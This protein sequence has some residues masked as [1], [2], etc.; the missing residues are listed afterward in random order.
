VEQAKPE[1]SP[2]RLRISD[3]MERLKIKS[4]AVNYN[5]TDLHALVAEVIDP[6][7]I[8]HILSHMIM[9]YSMTKHWNSYGTRQH[10]SMVG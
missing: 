2:E 8:A 3:D 5:T 1:L 9:G 6:E 4:A 7:V 10:G